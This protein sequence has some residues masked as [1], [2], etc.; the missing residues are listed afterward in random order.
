MLASNPSEVTKEFLCNNGKHLVSGCI[1]YIS[2][3]SQSTCSN[4][5]LCS[6][7][8]FRRESQKKWKQEHVN[9]TPDAC[10]FMRVREYANNNHE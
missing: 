4:E 1:K 5:I 10:E 9:V 2:D 3:C 8:N 6:S 7:S